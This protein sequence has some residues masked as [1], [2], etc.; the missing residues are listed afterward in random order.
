MQGG[1]AAFRYAKA[2]FSLAQD[3]HKQAEVRSEIEGLGQ[4]FT[5]NPEL[6]EA[7]LTPLRPAGERKGAL[8]AIAEKAQISRPVQNFLSYLIDQRRLIDFGDIVSAYAEL[9]DE[10][11]GLVTE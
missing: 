2:L 7:L 5:D 9:A 6:Q 4:L 3:D 1:T 10:S 11:A 8:G